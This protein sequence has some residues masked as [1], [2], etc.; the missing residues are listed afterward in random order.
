MVIICLGN[1]LI[2]IS[3]EQGFWLPFFEL[4]KPPNLPCSRTPD[5]FWSAVLGTLWL[6]PPNTTCIHVWAPDFTDVELWGVRRQFQ[7][8]LEALKTN[9]NQTNKKTNKTKTFLSYSSPKQLYALQKEGTWGCA[10]LLEV[11]WNDCKLGLY[12]CLENLSLTVEKK[13]FSS[14]PKDR[15]SKNLNFTHFFSAYSYSH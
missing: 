15:T 13:V 7:V 12:Q 10:V 4:G 3:P 9:N 8:F 5:R 2:V 14:K 6:L 1:T 11:A